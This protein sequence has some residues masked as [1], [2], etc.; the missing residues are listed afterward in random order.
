[1]TRQAVVQTV[2]SLQRQREQLLIRRD[3]MLVARVGHRQRVLDRHG[4]LAGV[5]IDRRESHHPPSLP[6]SSSRAP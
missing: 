3:Q 4:A 5:V 6:I 1:M 2:R